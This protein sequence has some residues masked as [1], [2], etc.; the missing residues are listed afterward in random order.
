M[1]VKAQR[2][3]A[4]VSTRFSRSRKCDERLLKT[5]LETT[6]RHTEINDWRRHHADHSAVCRYLR[7]RSVGKIIARFTERLTDQRQGSS[8][9]EMLFHFAKAE[10]HGTIIRSILETCQMTQRPDSIFRES[11][12][13]RWLK[14][15][16]VTFREISCNYTVKLMNYQLK[17]VTYA[18]TAGTLSI[19]WVA[20]KYCR[21][22]SAMRTFIAYSR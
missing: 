7:I 15:S 19:F 3:V 5:Y 8:K 17:K 10:S 9:P 16:W 1:K 22:P 14:H 12:N 13:Y 11:V 4:K 18:L 2:V 21:Q 20:L 6:L